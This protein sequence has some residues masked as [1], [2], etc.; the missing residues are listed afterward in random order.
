MYRSPVEQHIHD[1]SGPKSRG[2]YINYIR[3]L[4]RF[5]EDMAESV[6]QDALLTLWQQRDDV[7]TDRIGA[8]FHCIVRRACFR[9]REEW[10]AR[11][12]TAM[13]PADGGHQCS[14]ET[15]DA[16]HTDS[17]LIE[18]LLAPLPEADRQILREWSAAGR[19]NSPN[20][21]RSKRVRDRLRKRLCPDT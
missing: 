11:K 20:P 5:D 16:D 6:L 17:V 10:R 14:D 4:T 13:L 1:V 2:R 15:R 8:Y 3:G 12:E 18:R 21:Q 19:G 9:A 7:K